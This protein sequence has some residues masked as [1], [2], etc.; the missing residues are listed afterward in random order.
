EAP[1]PDTSDT[2]LE[3]RGPAAAVPAAGKR[4]VIPWWS[5]VLAALVI[6][7]AIYGHAGHIEVCVGKQGETDFTLSG[8]AR[9]DD[10]RWKFPRCEERVN[11]G[12]VSHR[13]QLT[14][15]AVHVACRG[16]TIFRHQG[17]GKACTEGKAGWEQHI[18]ASQCPPWHGHFYAHL[19]WFLK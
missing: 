9:T 18:E 6:E 1:G 5:F 8:Q 16:A 10:N 7:F 11:L 2:P 14:K 17:E 12:L 13:E 3:H 15:E 4:R 19:F